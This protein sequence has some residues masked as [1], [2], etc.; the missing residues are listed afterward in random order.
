MTI[1]K[2][3]SVEEI[4][5]RVC[6]ALEH[7]G[8]DVVLSGGGAVTLYS[9][10]E[11]MSTDLDFITTERKRRITPV[12]ASLGFKP[13]GREYVHPDSRFFIEFPA[14][15]LA[16]GDRY[17]DNS[18]ATTLK[19]QF[20]AIRVITP[21]QSVMDRL[22]WFVHGHDQQSRDQAIM[23]AK[24]QTIDWQAVFD[25]AKSENI[26]SAVVEKIREEANS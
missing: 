12:V 2:D 15:P 23:V 11:Y 25:W 7:A 17:V 19:T 22:A 1:S 13:R 10:N 18:E 24:H 16:F 14:G 9:E 5:A 26:D 4:A 8:I 20:G 6:E 21:T 3:T